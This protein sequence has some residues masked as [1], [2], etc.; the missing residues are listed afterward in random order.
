M[1]LNLLMTRTSIRIGRAK[2]NIKRQGISYN[3]K[4]KSKQKGLRRMTYPMIGMPG[5]VSLIDR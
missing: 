4:E 5:R 1:A 2:L 3:P